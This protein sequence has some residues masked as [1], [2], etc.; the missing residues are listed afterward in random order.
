MRHEPGSSQR[1]TK[2]RIDGTEQGS[3]GFGR[4]SVGLIKVLLSRLGEL[5]D[6]R[7]R[8]SEMGLRHGYTMEATGITTH[9][10]VSLS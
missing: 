4:L 1:R 5:L 10:R 6:G 7:I 9:R 3:G 8:I 2:V